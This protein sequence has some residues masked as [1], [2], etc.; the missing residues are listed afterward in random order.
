MN[1]F[2]DT[3]PLTCFNTFTDRNRFATTKWRSAMM[4][5]VFAIQ[6]IGQL[7][8]ALIALIVTVGFKS[9]LITS[10]KIGKCDH[11]CL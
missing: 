6:G 11:A 3:I 1:L 9:S 5:S 8:A 2:L 4:G 7:V 10:L